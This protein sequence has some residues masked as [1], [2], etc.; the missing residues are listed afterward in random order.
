MY[1]KNLREL[2]EYVITVFKD[3][4]FWFSVKYV[5]WILWDKLTG[6]DYV[7]NEGYEKLHTKPEESAVYQATRDIKY[8]NN[9]LDDLKITSE[10][11]ILDLGCGKGYLLKFFSRKGFKKVGGVEI[12]KELCEIAR[13]NLNKEQIKNFEIYNEN[14]ITFN[15]YEEYNYIYM[16]NPFPS[17]IMK[18]VIQN[19]EAAITND[20]D[21]III[22][23]NPICHNNVVSNGR[24]K[25]VNKYKG[26]S[27]EYY[28]Y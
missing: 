10:D 4:R 25:L 16:F 1:V 9:V 8:L 5:L 17:S 2:I 19:I 26:K 27:T 13:N 12:S 7:K 11:C 15:K 20:R 23:H 3:K 18:T 24:F 21:L 14:A 6:F 28:V 22:Y